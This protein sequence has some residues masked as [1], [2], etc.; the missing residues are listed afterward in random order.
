MDHS[1]I[2][3]ISSYQKVETTWDHQRH[4]ETNGQNER[5]DCYLWELILEL[6]TFVFVLFF[7]LRLGISCDF[8]KDSI[9]ITRF[10]SGL[11]HPATGED[12][13]IERKG[14]KFTDAFISPIFGDIQRKRKEFIAGLLPP[15]RGRADGVDGK[16]IKEFI[17]YI[18]YYYHKIWLIEK[19]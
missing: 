8:S 9:Y 3:L 17:I 6:S 2:H 7:H 16:S 1:F 4:S 19:K 5:D 13:R 10:I 15:T 12:K 11:T 18:I 14:T